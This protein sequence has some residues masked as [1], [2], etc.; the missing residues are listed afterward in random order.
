VT[1]AY[2]APPELAAAAPAAGPARAPRTIDVRE[3]ARFHEYAHEITEIF[4][5]RGV[6]TT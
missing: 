3:S 6:L 2:S 5:R 4:F 1:D